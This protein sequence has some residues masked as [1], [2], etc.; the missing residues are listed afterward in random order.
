[1]ARTPDEKRAADRAAK[2][3]YYAKLSPEQR[4]RRVRA[5]AEARAHK[6]EVETIEQTEARRAKYRAYSQQHRDRN[7]AAYNAGRRAYG[8]S[9][10][11]K[12]KTELFAALGSRCSACR[13]DDWRVLQ[14]DHINGGGGAHRR[15]SGGY[16]Y[17]IAILRSVK[18]GEG[19]YQL[20]CANCHMLKSYRQ[21]EAAGRAP[22]LLAAI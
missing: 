21:A 20:L 22:G 13:I 3:G 14:V 5:D 9:K 16:G 4:A 12:T 8:A 19:L 2:Q 6:R 15:R 11:I 10:T 17:W 1:M 18:S 7:R